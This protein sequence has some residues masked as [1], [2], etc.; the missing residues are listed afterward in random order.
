MISN[1]SCLLNTHHIFGGARI[2]PHRLLRNCNL[3]SAGWYGVGRK[4]TVPEVHP[5]AT[6][7]GLNQ[8]PNLFQGLPLTPQLQCRRIRQCLVEKELINLTE[9]CLCEANLKWATHGEAKWPSRVPHHCPAGD[10]TLADSSPIYT[11]G[12]CHQEQ[13]TA[14]FSQIVAS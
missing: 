13:S 4:L 14:Q 9:E 10:S 12:F 1:E 11:G 5:R 7:S 6:L 8:Q 3:V 2:G